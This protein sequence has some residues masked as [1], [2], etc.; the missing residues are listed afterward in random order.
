[1]L[2]ARLRVA[3]HLWP[4]ALSRSQAARICDDIPHLDDTS[5]RHRRIQWRIADRD[6]QDSL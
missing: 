5:R 1:M 6:I 4:S 2:C 3:A